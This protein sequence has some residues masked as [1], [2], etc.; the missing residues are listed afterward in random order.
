MLRG[1]VNGK[2][3][4]SAILN[5]NLKSA[6][7]ELAVEG[8]GCQTSVLDSVTL[9]STKISFLDP[10]ERTGTGTGC[11]QP[12]NSRDLVGRQKQTSFTINS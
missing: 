4:P 8:L 11:A 1:Y 7:S 9:G 12:F 10:Y 6:E 3:H 2:L 5:C